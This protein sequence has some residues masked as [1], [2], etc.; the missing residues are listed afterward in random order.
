MHFFKTVLAAFVPACL[1]RKRGAVY[2]GFRR[3]SP[4]V[5]LLVNSY[6][7]E[8]RVRLLPQ[9]RHPQHAIG[10]CL[11]SLR[12]T[13]VGPV[14]EETARVARA[15]FAKGNAW[16]Q[17]RDVLG[18]VYDDASFAALF[19]PQGRPAETPWR[20]ALVTVMQFAEWLSDRQ[21]A[22]AVRA[23][24][25]WKYALGLE[26]GPTEVRTTTCFFPA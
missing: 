20:L 5:I 14:P 18:A 2:P 11:M 6:A 4:F 26:L 7:A 25:D 22:E 23:R 16:M 15:A 10:R 3:S 21:A 12:P 9:G 13:E 24:I 1:S 8:K 19:A 17:M